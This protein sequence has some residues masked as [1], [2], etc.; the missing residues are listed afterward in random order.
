MAHRRNVESLEANLLTY[1]PAGAGG[2][3]RAAIFAAVCLLQIST[4]TSSAMAADPKDP[5]DTARLRPEAPSQFWNGPTTSCANAGKLPDP[6]RLADTIDQALC[7]NPQTRQSW[8]NAKVQAA[9]V[10]AARA[11][12]LPDLNATATLQRNETRNLPAA[13]GQTTSNGGQT[14]L[15]GSLSLNYLLFDFGGRDATLEL[16]QQS[17][18]AADWTHNSTLQIVLLSAV[19]SYYLLYA[20]EQAVQSNLSAEK[21][22]LASLEAARARQR[23]GSATRADTL[24]AQTAYSQA[25]LNRTQAEG[26]AATAR[27]VLANSL[28]LSADRD[29]HIAP[30]PDLEAQKVAE[31]AIADLLEVA[32]VKRPDFAAAQALVR[33]AESNITVQES[34]G[35]P[36][37]SV[38]ATAGATQASGGLDPRTGSIGVQVNIPLF[39]GYRTTY[40]ILQAREQ[41]EAQVASRDKL[42]TDISLDVW[43]AYQ[44]L[45]TQ[46]QSLATATE[47]TASAQESYDVALARYKAGV[48]TITELLNAQ[49]ALA[50]AQLQ[51]IQARYR[52]N[53]AK[54]TLARAIGVLEPGL[55]AEHIPSPNSPN[56][57]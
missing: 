22:S 32:K 33:A 21:A 43:R 4:G 42:A 39:T 36:N 29:L 56:P 1:L 20:A 7:N 6:L 30:P 11:A 49:S 16:A 38:F 53:L 19:Q 34:A 31:R 9:Q 12:Y 52:W 10:G 24:Q 48:G 17:L 13:T 47:L 25:Q 46:D 41:L 27:G 14:V 35:K 26:D 3:V 23:V 8:A 55:L 18:Q 5:F 28:G 50:S 44:D 54:V 2:R 51:K 57:R 15:N 45:R 40:Q 37:I